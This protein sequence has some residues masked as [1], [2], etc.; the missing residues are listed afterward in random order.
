MDS[1]AI[2]EIER[3]GKTAAT[4]RKPIPLQTQKCTG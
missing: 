3:G 2:V 4:A 1:N